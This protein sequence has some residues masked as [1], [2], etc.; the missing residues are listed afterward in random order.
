MPSCINQHYCLQASADGRELGPDIIGR[1]ARNALL[2]LLWRVK[3]QT[4][5]AN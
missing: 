1:A 4:T 3:V 2:A 5:S